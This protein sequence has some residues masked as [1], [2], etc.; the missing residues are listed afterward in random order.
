MNEV[1]QSITTLLEGGT[2]LFGQ[3]HTSFPCF[4][5]PV[6]PAM[7]DVQSAQHPCQV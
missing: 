1:K 5:M 3:E 4:L 2:E 7:Q 6:S